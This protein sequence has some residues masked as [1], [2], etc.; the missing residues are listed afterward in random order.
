MFII[1]FFQDQTEE[2]TYRGKKG[3]DGNKRYRFFCT[4]YT[5][6]N[7]HNKKS[8]KDDTRNE[9]RQKDMV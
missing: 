3:Y 5:Y 6:S 7:G 2:K 8:P 9:Q 4:H 1:L